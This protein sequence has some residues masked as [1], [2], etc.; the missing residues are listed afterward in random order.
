MTAPA[1]TQTKSP[2]RTRAERYA[3]MAP[4]GATVEITDETTAYGLTIAQV[5]I[6][7][8]IDTILV[9]ISNW[10][11]KTRTRANA[12]SWFNSHS[13]ADRKIT[14]G[15]LPTRIRSLYVH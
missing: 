9:T 1:E 6:K 11:G 7:G 13:Q 5:S 15:Y 3:A 12:T 4:A 8:S 2:S 14:L 10:T